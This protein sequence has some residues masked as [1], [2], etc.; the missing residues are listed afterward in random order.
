EQFATY[1]VNGSEQTHLMTGN[2]HGSGAIGQS[3]LDSLPNPPR[4]IGAKFIAQAIIELI[5]GAH[6]AA[7]AFLDKVG[8]GQAAA[9][10]ALGN[11]N[12]QPQ[13]GLGELTSGPLIYT[14][15]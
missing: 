10:V 9:A 7:I 6:Q 11:R 14:P 15:T 8:K 12:H 5:D 3:P 4:R 1:S 13:V 2:A